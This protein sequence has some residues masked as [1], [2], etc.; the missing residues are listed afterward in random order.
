M[1]V[2]LAKTLTLHF[3]IYT[4]TLIPLTFFFFLFE[5][6]MLVGLICPSWVLPQLVAT[7]WY[8]CSSP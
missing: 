5:S 6:R 2:K 1:H 7:E 3:I 4:Y 8:L